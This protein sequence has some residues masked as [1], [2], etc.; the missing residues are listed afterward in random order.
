M[1]AGVAGG[2]WANHELAPGQTVRIGLP[3][4]LAV[5]ELEITIGFDDD[6]MVGAENQQS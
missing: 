5:G 3:L 2:Q 4:S 6:M 1:G